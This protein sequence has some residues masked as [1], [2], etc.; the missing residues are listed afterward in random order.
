M[1]N[2]MRQVCTLFGN[3]LYSW[4]NHMRSFSFTYSDS[5]PGFFQRMGI[6]LMVSSFQASRLLMFSSDGNQLTLLP[7]LFKRCMAIDALQ[8][9]IVVSDARHVLYF[10]NMPELAESYPRQPNTYSDL[11]VPRAQWTTGDL[12]IHDIKLTPNGILAVNTKFSCI[13]SIGETYSFV[14]IWKP[15]FISALEPEDRC[16]LNGFACVDNQPEYATALGQTDTAEGWRNSPDGGVLIHIPTQQIVAS[17]LS[18]PHS[19]RIYNNTVLFTEASDG[20][21]SSYSPET[22]KTRTLLEVQG[23]ARGLEIFGD[24]A[25]VGVSGMRKGSKIAHLTPEEF[26]SAP[27]AIVVFDLKTLVEVG[28]I[29]IEGDLT[30][31]SNLKVLPNIKRPGILNMNSNLYTRI[32]STPDVSYWVP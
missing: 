26:L 6:S 20:T 17:E 22:G 15:D 11:Y 13:C 12:D 8:N 4:P 1:V 16:H 31:L 3:I 28:R 23:F 27:A 21:L 7:R 30:E 19:P 14:P 25:F 10:A 9:N 32:V 2:M 29:T 5:L 24:F 18:M